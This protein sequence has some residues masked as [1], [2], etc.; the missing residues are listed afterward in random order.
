MPFGLKM[1]RL[2]IT[3]NPQNSVQ[4]EKIRLAPINASSQANSESPMSVGQANAMLRNPL[5]IS[6]NLLG[7]MWDSGTNR[8]KRHDYRGPSLS[9]VSQHDYVLTLELVS[10]FNLSR[11]H[12]ND[13]VALSTSQDLRRIPD[14]SSQCKLDSRSEFLESANRPM[15]NSWPSG[16]RDTSPAP[17]H[18]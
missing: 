17:H 4:P 2:K 9:G 6:A 1:N 3:A 10:R 15:P 12:T 13:G 5:A 18:G 7:A 11:M 14:T 16:D 8:A